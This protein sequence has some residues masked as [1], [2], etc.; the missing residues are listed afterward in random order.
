M[1]YIP[2]K[3]LHIRHEGV[4]S[5]SLTRCAGRWWWGEDIQMYN[6]QF[7]SSSYTQNDQTASGNLTGTRQTEGTITPVIISSNLADTWGFPKGTFK[8][9]Y[10]VLV[11][12]NATTSP[13]HY[14]VRN[15]DNV[16]AS[17]YSPQFIA[18]QS[19]ET[20]KSNLRWIDYVENSTNYRLYKQE[21]ELVS[22]PTYVTGWAWNDRA[23]FRFA[24][25]NN[26][27]NEIL[28][29]PFEDIKITQLD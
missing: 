1:V 6:H 20:S 27:T 24:N 3:T 11:T 14:R 23:N 28:T 8:I 26:T 5:G 19:L 17:G 12:L 16:G 4:T 9:E 10:E 18:S 22:T 7:Y 21:F 2:K 29:M 25:Q 13:T 15:S